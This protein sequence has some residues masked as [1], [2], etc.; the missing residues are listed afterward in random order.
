MSRVVVLRPEPGASET[1]ARA[2]QLGLEPIRVPLFEV[3]PIAWEAP[4][5]A[6]FDALLLTSANAIRYAGERLSGLRTLPVHA[7]G[8]ATAQTAREAGFDVASVGE[9][10]VDTLLDSLDPPLRLLHLCGEDRREPQAA[11]QTITSLVVYRS[12]DRADVDVSGAQGAIVLIHSPRAGRRFAELS[13][14][15]G[16]TSIAAISANAADAAGD[17]WGRVEIAEQ[18]NDHALLALAARLCNKPPP[19]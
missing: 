16:S 4:N 19:Q 11:R 13:G 2:R 3:E 17:G 1:A 7:V 10:R 6:G 9:A 8:E 14:E 5:P 15:R 18:P 12:K